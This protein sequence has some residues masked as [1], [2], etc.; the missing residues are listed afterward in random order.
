MVMLPQ[1]VEFP[2][3]DADYHLTLPGVHVLFG[4][5]ITIIGPEH[6]FPRA[7][8]PV[9]SVPAGTRFTNISTA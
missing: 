2:R 1:L 8:M 3:S 9:C 4:R 5:T 7:Q 6:P